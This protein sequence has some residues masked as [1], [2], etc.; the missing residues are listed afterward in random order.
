MRV[1]NI[2][3]VFE[4]LWN[5]ILVCPIVLA[6]VLA[7]TER[8]FDDQSRVDC[9]ACGVGLRCSSLGTERPAALGCEYVSPGEDSI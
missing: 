5:I 8:C 4:P 9:G 7:S 6:A 2:V 3:V 1:S